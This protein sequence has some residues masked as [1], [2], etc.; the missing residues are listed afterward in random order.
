MFLDVNLREF[1]TTTQASLVRQDKILYIYYAMN[2]SRQRQ[3]T[4]ISDA[5]RELPIQAHIRP[6]KNWKSRA[7]A[8]YLKV[9]ILFINTI[10]SKQTTIF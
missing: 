7:N 5:E 9:L 2:T 8:I 4:N 6:E 1:A 10:N 3:L